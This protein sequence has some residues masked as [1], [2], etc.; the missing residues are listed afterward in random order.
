MEGVALA[1]LG[2]EAERF[3]FVGPAHAR[4]E[5]G[6]Q[7][8]VWGYEVVVAVVVHDGLAVGSYAGVNDAK[9]DGA[10]GEVVV[11]LREDEGGRANVSRLYLMGDVYDACTR[12]EVGE[13]RFDGSDVPVGFAKIG[14][15]GDDGSRGVHGL[16]ESAG[17]ELKFS[18]S[19]EL[20]TGEV[21]C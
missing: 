11:A 21:V 8:V 15:E 10:A 3:D 6:E 9:E 18:R 4:V 17:I 19:E 5:E 2:S 14:Q 13:N 1:C 12:T 16:V 7:A 20:A